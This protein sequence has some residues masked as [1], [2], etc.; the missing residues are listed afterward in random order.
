MRT[1]VIVLTFLVL[2]GVP[3]SAQPP[4]P[5][6]EQQWILADVIA[7]IE[8]MS[9]KT[10]LPAPVITEHVWSPA[11]YRAAAEAAFRPAPAD[12]DLM[13]RIALVDLNSATLLEQSSRVSLVLEG[14]LRRPAA[15]EAAALLLGGMAL[16]EASGWF[17]DVPSRP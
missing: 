12:A 2:S 16:R 13:V 4:H 6:T 10:S 14:D 17:D 7:A 11:T 9:G 8:G 5:A 3:A 15:H 1:I